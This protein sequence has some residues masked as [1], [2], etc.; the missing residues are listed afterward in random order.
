MLN[1]HDQ[2]IRLCDGV[3]RR[4]WL[5]VGSLGMLGLSTPQ[6]WASRPASI[7]DHAVGDSSL[8]RAR[9]CILIFLTGGPPQHETW[10]PKPDAPDAVRGDFRPIASRTV[11]LRVGELMPRTSRLTDKIAVLRAMSTRDSAHSSSGY[12]MLTGNAHQP[13]NFESARAGAPNNWPCMGAVV[14]HLRSSNGALPSAITLP[15]DIHNNP[16]IPW[17]GQTAGFLGQANDP[18]MLTCD[19]NSP[20]FR[21]PSLTLPDDLPPVRF[22]QRRSL[23]QQVNRQL[24]GLESTPTMTRYQTQSEQAFDLLRSGQVRRAFE[25]QREP[26][27]VRDRYGRHKFGQS[28]LLARRLVESGVPLV[29]VNWPR[30]P[31]DSNANNPVWDTHSNNSDRLRTALMPPMDTGYSALLEDLDARGMLDET[32]IVWMGEFG[33]TPR[34]NGRRGRDHWGHVFSVA[35][36]GGGIRGGVV[37][38]ASDDQGGQPREGLVQPA[39]LTAT[40][41]HCLGYRAST[42]I[43]DELGRPVMISRGD[44]VRSVLR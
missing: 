18:W 35:L 11:G 32:L 22:D 10:D 25:L 27:S 8:G 19:P 12:F 4:D 29:Q 36:A 20:D 38:G 41:F 34:I 6:L 42:E 28:L 33:R 2:H 1:L 31:G 7:P 15:E 43:H 5:R 13:M 26:V 37:H 30:E 17:P 24:D 23:L 9:A 39:D 40:I 16:N 21:V 3:T 14:K 44:I